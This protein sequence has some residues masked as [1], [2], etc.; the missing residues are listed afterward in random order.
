M[1]DKQTHAHGITSEEEQKR[2]GIDR[3]YATHSTVPPAGERKIN[4]V[5]QETSQTGEERREHSSAYQ[6]LKYKNERHTRDET[7]STQVKS[8]EQRD[9]HGLKETADRA[10]SKSLDQRKDIGLTEPRTEPHRQIDTQ[11]IH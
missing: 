11:N 5:N 4:Y 2:M 7:S 1:S 10:D 9:S 6:N 8:V 3:P